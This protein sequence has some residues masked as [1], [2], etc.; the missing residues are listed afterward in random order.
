MYQ[1]YIIFDTLTL[2][3]LYHSRSH[4]I[5][6]SPYMISYWCNNSN[7]WP[8]SVALWDISL[9]NLR[10]LILTFQGHSKSNVI[11]PLIQLPIYGFLLMFNSNIWPNSTPL[12]DI[13]F[14]NVSDLDIDFS[15]SLRVPLGSMLMKM[16]KSCY[17]FI[18]QK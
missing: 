11:V 1:F 5:L 3:F 9:W 4:V 8:N 10:D 7:I 18:F 15:R 6:D 13:S 16:N 2:T 12:P 14:Q 17:N